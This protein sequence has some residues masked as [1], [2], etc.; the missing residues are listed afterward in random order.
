MTIN[1]QGTFFTIKICWRSLF[2]F[3]RKQCCGKLKTEMSL[4]CDPY[5]SL[6]FRVYNSRKSCLDEI[7]YQLLYL[8]VPWLRFIINL[9][10]EHNLDKK[11]QF[12]DLS[13]N[14]VDQD[15]F[16]FLSNISIRSNS[17][18]WTLFNFSE[19]TVRK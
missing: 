18:P 15:W 2:L 14:L 9:W 11:R 12:E 7:D 4:P 6:S 10:F 1:Y 17:L 13:Q 19:P 8:I 5:K 16:D 3:S